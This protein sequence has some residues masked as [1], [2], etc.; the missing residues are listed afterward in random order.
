[1]REIIRISVEIF[2]KIS[3]QDTLI[4]ITICFDYTCKI[5]ILIIFNIRRYILINLESKL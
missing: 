4:I 2:H 5:Y 3:R 1:M